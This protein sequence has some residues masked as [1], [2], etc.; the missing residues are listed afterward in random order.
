MEIKELKE[1]PKE[2]TVVFVEAVVMPQ[3]EVICQGKTVGWRNSKTN[4]IPIYVK[5]YG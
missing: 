4:S 3:G 1:Q 5:K 2:I